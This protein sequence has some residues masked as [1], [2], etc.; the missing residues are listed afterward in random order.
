MNNLI[1]D[2][3]KLAQEAATT[4]KIRH[5]VYVK[6]RYVDGAYLSKNAVD[7]RY[8]QMLETALKEQQEFAEELQRIAQKY[9]PPQLVASPNWAPVP[10]PAHEYTI[11]SYPIGQK[12]NAGA[13]GS[14]VVNAQE[15]L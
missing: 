3:N 9:T 11:T 4:A 6:Q 1:L 8:I 10:K 12:L 13:G 2:L 14:G 7:K 15:G 5:D